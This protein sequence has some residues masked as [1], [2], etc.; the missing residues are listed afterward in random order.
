MLN[1]VILTGRLTATHELKTTTGGIS[2]TTFSIAVQRQYKSADG[3]Y[4]TD[5]INI[6]AWR[7]TAEFITRFFEK[8]QLIAIVGSIQTRNYEDKTGAK[9]TAVEVVADEAQF[10]ESKRDAAAAAGRSVGEFQAPAE[11]GGNTMSFEE[12]ED[13]ELPF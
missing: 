10:V 6:V 2:V 13:D 1:K 4:P 7:S 5:F 9:R 12:V 11:T 3:S 8:G